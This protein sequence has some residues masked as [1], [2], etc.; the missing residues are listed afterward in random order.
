MKLEVT[1]FDKAGKDNT[2]EVMAIVKKRAQEL[3]IKTVV[4]ASYRGY[5]ADKAV[6]ALDGMKIIAVMGFL[7]PNM[8]NL[9]ETFS[10]GDEKLIKSKATVLIA[11]HLFSGINRAMRKKYDTSSPGEIIAQALRTISVG[12][13]VGIECTLMAADAALVHTDEDVIAIAGT[14]A[15]ADTAIVLRP[16]NSQ[17]FFDLK[18]KEILCKPREW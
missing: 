6:R 12:V 17:D 18:V 2:D 14:R 13:K 16:V 1:Y 3:G 11:T 7:E 15:G 5:T 10:Q 8:Q 4:V 9:A